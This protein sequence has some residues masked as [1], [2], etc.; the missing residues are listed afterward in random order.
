MN[1]TICLFDLDGTLVDTLGDIAASLNV[2]LTS[3][4]MPAL[5][6]AQTSA[7]VGH[8]TKYMFEHAVPQDRSAEWEQVGEIYNAHYI[9]HCCDSSRPYEGVVET[10]SALKNAGVLLAVV[11]NK[12]HAMAI[13]VIRTLFAR[14]S[15]QMVLGRMERFGTKPAP[16]MLQFALD[17]FGKK[18]E[19]AVYV[20]DSE[21]DVAFAANAGVECLS[22]SWGLRT[23]RQLVDAGA[24]RIIDDPREVAEIL[25]AKP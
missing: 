1:K 6:V 4:R 10:V 5:S 7:I 22:A 19:E 16:D 20:G 25:L 15:F 17:Y 11:T 3:L 13:E 2:A 12:P 18:T 14:D 8:S 9:R 24:A 23:R 21:V